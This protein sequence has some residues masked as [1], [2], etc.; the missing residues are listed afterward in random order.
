M[1][2][3]NRKKLTCLAMA[4]AFALAMGGAAAAAPLPVANVARDVSQAKLDL[5]VYR[6]HHR[7]HHHYVY[8]HRPYRHYYYRRYYNPGA[9]AA[10]AG[11]VLG[12]FGGAAAAASGYPYYGYPYYGGYYYGYG[13]GYYGYGYGPGY[14]YGY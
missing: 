4:G 5:V 11:T 8:R 12:L 14:Y 7:G 13:P 10:V 6:H 2:Q 3:E 1:M 9:G